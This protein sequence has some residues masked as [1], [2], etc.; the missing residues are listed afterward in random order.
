MHFLQSFIG[1]CEWFGENYAYN[2]GFIPEDKLGWKPVPTA[3]S[4]YEISHHLA[5]TMLFMKQALSGDGLKEVELSMPT[6][7]SEAQELILRVTKDYASWMAGL[8]P[9]DLEGDIELPFGTF[10]R[11]L[12]VGM[13][14]QDLVHH[15]GQIT[16]IQ[17]LL[18][19]TDFHFH[20]FGN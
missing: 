5:S 13:E 1:T 2:L 18:G 3:N 9:Q 10:P 4:A 15:H 8:S 6:S 20:D 12:A 7:K 19:D 17:S 16:Y 14:V 11:M